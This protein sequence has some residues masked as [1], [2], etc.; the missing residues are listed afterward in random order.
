MKVLLS[1]S[2]TDPNSVNNDGV[3]ILDKIIHNDDEAT[4][5]S[6]REEIEYLLRAA[7]AQ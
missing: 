2:D 1:H 3:S 6:C 4:V 7:G 5:L